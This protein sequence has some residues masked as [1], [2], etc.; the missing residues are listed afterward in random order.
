MPGASHCENA[1]RHQSGLRDA[2]LSNPVEAARPRPNLTGVDAAN[3]WKKYIQLTEAEWTFR[4][5]KKT[6]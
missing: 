2:A 4:I 6:S 3:L 1:L 5:T